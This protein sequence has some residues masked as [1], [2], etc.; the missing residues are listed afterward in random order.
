MR[1][2]LYLYLHGYCESRTAAKTLIE[3]AAFTVDGKLVTKPSFAVD[4]TAEHVISVDKTEKRY[5]SRGGLKLD[6]AL[7]EFG[8]SAENRI[9]L[10]VGAS[11]GGFTDCLLQNGASRVFAVDS[12]TGQLKDAIKRDSRVYSIEGYNARYMKREDFPNVPSLAV[13]DVSF[14][15]ATYL[16]EAVYS[17]LSD[18]GEFILLVKPQFEVGRQNVGKGGIVKDDS[19]RKLA[20]SSV[21][22]A[23]EA[24]GFIF[25]GQMRSPIKGGDGNVEFLAYF[26]KP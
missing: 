26:K 23:A 21:I 7:S 15:S 17:V 18:G 2:D 8:V 20:L 14:I 9:C 22:S 12:G 19:L 6:A 11:S 16:L 24:L 5:V 10:D 3:N 13:M 25:C 4:T 1:I